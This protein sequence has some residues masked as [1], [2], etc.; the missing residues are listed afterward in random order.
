MLPSTPSLE[1]LGF[2]GKAVKKIPPRVDESERV[3]RLI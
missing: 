1:L 2:F 3:W